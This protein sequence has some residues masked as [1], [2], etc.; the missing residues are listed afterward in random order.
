MI[1]PIWS[2]CLTAFA[3]TAI[4]VGPRHRWGWIVGIVG[5]CVWLIYGIHSH[6]HGFVLSALLLATAY[7]RNFIN[8]GR[9]K[10]DANAAPSGLMRLEER[11]GSPRNCTSAPI[12]LSADD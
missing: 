12:Q 2:W 6:Q 5:Q 8:A 4:W 11:A 1:D 3:V 9:K 7:L 10:P